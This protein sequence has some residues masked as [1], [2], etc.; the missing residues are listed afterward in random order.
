MYHF[1]EI[2]LNNDFYEQVKA[3]YTLDKHMSKVFALV[4]RDSIKLHGPST[5]FKIH[6][7]LMFHQDIIDN[8][9]RLCIPDTLTGDVFD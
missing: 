4:D 8:R 9:L 1:S 5:H 3:V 6:N 7:D 2:A